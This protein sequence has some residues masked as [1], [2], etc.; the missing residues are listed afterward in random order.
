[1]TLFSM[2]DVYELYKKMQHNNIMLSFKG[3]VTPELIS[4][5]LNIIEEKLDKSHESTK[6]KK[7]VFNVLVECLQNLY[8]HMG[9][10]N[11]ITD[12]NDPDMLGAKSAILLIW[13]EDSGY[14]IITGNH[15]LKEAV[16]KLKSRLDT[17]NSLSKDELREL[18]QDILSNQGFSA[19]G[20]A[21]LGMVDI[22]R[23]S[24][25]KLD[26]NFH[27]VNDKLSFFSLQINISEK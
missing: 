18:Y 15:I 2:S 20:G 22:A 4:S 11:P 24:G 16:D 19:K 17:I 7:K 25:E 5:F 10:L 27:P 14:Y 23:K 8:H 6:I 13:K 1:M 3:E 21:G 12:G 26:Y 9:D